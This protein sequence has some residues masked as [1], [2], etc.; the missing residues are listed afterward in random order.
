MVNDRSRT[1]AVSDICTEGGQLTGNDLWVFAYGSLMWNPGFSFTEVT[2]ARLYGYCRNLCIYS[3]VYRGSSAVPGLVLGL[4]HGG[5][6]QG[7]AFRVTPALRAEVIAYLRK[8]EQVNNVY[9]EKWLKL[10]LV[11]QRQ[12]TALVYVAD[13]DHR[14]YAGALEQSVVADIVRNAS[15]QA[16]P[17]AEY[18]RNTVQHLQQM[19]IRDRQLEAIAGF[20]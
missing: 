14:Q 3:H 9:L 18:V 7:L 1:S 17:N 16:G 5:S 20:L 6:C 2:P 4:D 13:K 11:D 19:A 10:R 15:G 12:V 8:R